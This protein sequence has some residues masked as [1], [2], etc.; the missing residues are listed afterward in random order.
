MEMA[1]LSNDCRDE[2]EAD[3][4]INLHLLCIFCLQHANNFLLAVESI[5]SLYRCYIYY[6]TKILYY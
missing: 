2:G 6:N 3:N 5:G 1:F 4:Y